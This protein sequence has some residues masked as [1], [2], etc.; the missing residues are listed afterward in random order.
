MAARDY[1]IPI[2]LHQLELRQ[3][4][5]HLL[6]SAPG[7]PVEGQVFYN[8][9]THVV[10]FYNGTSWIVVGT[11]DQMSAA[12]DVSLGSHKLTNVTDPTSAQDAAT[13]NYVDAQA[14]GARDVKDSVR[15]ATAAALPAYTRTANVITATGNGALAAVD[16]VTLVLNDRLLLKNGAA[17]A[18]NGPYYVSQVGTGGTPYT[19][20][21][22]TDADASAEVTAGMFVW[23]TE[24]TAN[25]DT[26]WLLTTADPITLNTT[27]L[28]FTQVSAL[29]QVTAG[30]G[31]TKTG[32][33]LDVGA[34]AGINVAADTVLTDPTLIPTAYA[35]DIGDGSTTSIVVTHGLGSKDV[36]V[37]VYDKTT[38]FSEQYPEVRHTSTTT[39]TLVFAVA[40]TAAQYRV[41]IVCLHG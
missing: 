19:L 26:G 18:D 33:T 1:R 11:L 13:K 5:L 35:A 17:G 22:T 9:A 12:A 7:S 8:T 15:V 34:G 4:V 36:I 10:E 28:T 27:S 30:N 16:G 20:T 31:L 23:A 29:G 37:A 21:R 39:V 3:A 38:P 24:G 32:S 14:A 6:G 2:D 41:L 25:A 40:P